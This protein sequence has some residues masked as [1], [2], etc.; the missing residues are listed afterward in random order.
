MLQFRLL[1]LLSIQDKAARASAVNECMALGLLAFTTTIIQP[2]DRNFEPMQV[3]ALSRLQAALKRTHGAEWAPHPIMLI[4]LLTIA[5]LCASGAH[6]QSWL[7]TQLREVFR[8]FN[9]TSQTAL[10][11][12]LEEV[13]WITSRLR[14]LTDKLWNQLYGDDPVEDD[15]EPDRALFDGLQRADGTSGMESARVEV[16]RRPPYKERFPSTQEGS[17]SGGGTPQ[18][19]RAQGIHSKTLLPDGTRP[20]FSDRKHSSALF[21]RG[22]DA[23]DIYRTIYTGSESIWSEAAVAALRDRRQGASSAAS[24]LLQE[25]SVTT[26]L[27]PFASPTQGSSLAGSQVAYPE[28]DISILG[29]PD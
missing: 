19:E 12:T 6:Q 18:G 5:S 2:R 14:T 27:D 28:H 8:I 10:E 13:L 7:A 26:P 9:I 16:D 4:W 21:R 29:L 3:N 15:G 23:L 20:S 11:C 24:T 25:S 1:E 17:S 22:A